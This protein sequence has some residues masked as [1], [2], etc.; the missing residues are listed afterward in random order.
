MAELNPNIPIITLNENGLNTPMK[1][2]GKKTKP[3]YVLH[4]KLTS[5]DIG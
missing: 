1:R 5:N 2:Q 3:N 4:K